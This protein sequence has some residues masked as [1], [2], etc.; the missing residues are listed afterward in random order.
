V[1]APRTIVVKTLL[2]AD[3]F[4]EFSQQCQAD[5]VTQSKKLRDLARGWLNDR[6]LMRAT[7]RP[8]DPALA[9]TWPCCCRGARTTAHPACCACAFEADGAWQFHLT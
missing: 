4:V 2:N 1:K 8:E 7:S 9:R 3:E 5:D 6:M